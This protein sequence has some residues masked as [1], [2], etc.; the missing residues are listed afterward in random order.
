M[1]ATDDMTGEELA[2]SLLRDVGNERMR[3]ATRLLGAHRDGFWLRRFLDDQELSD[4]AGNPLI[5]SS[6]THPSVDW[7]A[8]GRLMLTLGWSRRSSSSEVAVPEFAA[9][10]VGSGAVQLQQVI[11]AVDEGEFRLLVRALE[12]AAYGERR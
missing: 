4:A 2:D 11:Q 5:D 3:A 7:T 10:L 9:S 12:E 8:L 6:G 1:M